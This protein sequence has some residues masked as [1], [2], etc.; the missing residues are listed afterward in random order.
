MIKYPDINPVLLKLGPIKIHWYGVMYLIG[1]ILI[2]LCA[3]IRVRKSKGLWTSEQLS[4]LIFYGIIGVLLGGRLGYIVFYNLPYYLSNPSEI[5]KVWDGGMSF[6]GGL[7][8]VITA[9]IIFAKKNRKNLFQVGDFIVPFVP[10]GLGAGR[11]GNF[12]NGEL[13]GKTTTIPWAMV[14]PTD[15]AQLPRHPSML[16][17]F[18]LEGIVLFI[19]LWFYSRKTRPRMAVS[20][21]FLLLYGIFRFAVEFVRAPD[22]QLGYLAWGWLTMGQVLSFPMIIIGTAWFINAYKNHKLVNGM[23]TDDIKYLK[24]LQV[25]N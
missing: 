5:I 12:I 13:W 3:S 23:N 22:P 15:P 10:I 9:F 7:I 2:W 16:Y 1:F 4:D 19:I 8:G 11:I 18:L 14:F 6:H 17:E 21:L 20:G 25:N 24:K